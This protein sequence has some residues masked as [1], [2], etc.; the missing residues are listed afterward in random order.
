MQ[1]AIA[2]R[3]LERQPSRGGLW[4]ARAQ[5]PQNYVEGKIPPPVVNPWN[6]AVQK[7]IKI[8]VSTARSCSSSSADFDGRRY[9]KSNPRSTSGSPSRMISKEDTHEPSMLAI[10]F[11]FTIYVTALNCFIS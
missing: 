5:V 7:P 9:G 4:S 2:H 11:K 6:L 10:L 1:L 3:V 8:D